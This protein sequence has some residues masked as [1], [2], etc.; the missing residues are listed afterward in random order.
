MSSVASSVVSSVKCSGQRSSTSPNI[1]KSFLERH[2]VPISKLTSKEEVPIVVVGNQ[3]K[4]IALTEE[5][6]LSEPSS[7]TVHT[8]YTPKIHFFRRTFPSRDHGSFE[9]PLAKLAVRV[10]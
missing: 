8:L 2:R 7:H 6:F 3:V 10:H 1:R 5:R 9:V 4:T